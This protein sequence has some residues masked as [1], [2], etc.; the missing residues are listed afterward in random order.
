MRTRDAAEE[1][2]S[3]SEQG[4]KGLGSWTRSPPIRGPHW[5]YIGLTPTR[6]LFFSNC[7]KTMLKAY[8][9]KFAVFSVSKH[10]VQRHG[11]Q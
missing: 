8:N 2:S 9:M 7:L 11:A 4:A 5:P 1:A 10:T 6:D 3:Q